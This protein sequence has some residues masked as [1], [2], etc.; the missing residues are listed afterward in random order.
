VGPEVHVEH[1]ITTG[2]EA[3]RRD[4]PKL[5]CEVIAA[6]SEHDKKSNLRRKVTHD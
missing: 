6:E 4:L 3:K 1:V 2:N 5:V